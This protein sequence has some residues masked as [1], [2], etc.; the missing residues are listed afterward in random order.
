MISAH[1]ERVF[2]YLG[3]FHKQQLTSYTSRDKASVLVKEII[4]INSH[5]YQCTFNVLSILDMLLLSCV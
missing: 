2:S 5:L 4:K 3:V 1:P